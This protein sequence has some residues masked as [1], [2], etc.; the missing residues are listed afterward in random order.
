[1]QG[2]TKAKM[3]ELEKIINSDK[4]IICLTGIHQKIDKIELD[5]SLSKISAMPDLGDKKGGGLMIVYK[6]LVILT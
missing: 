3:A 6:I 1:M 5:D 2:L 4:D